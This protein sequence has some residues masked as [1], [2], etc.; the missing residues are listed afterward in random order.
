MPLS[1]QRKQVERYHRKPEVVKARTVTLS[2]LEQLRAVDEHFPVVED[3][4]GSYIKLATFVNDDTIRVSEFHIIRAH[5]DKD[6]IVAVLSPNSEA[7][8]RSFG[9]K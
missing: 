5:R 9:R 7:K 4:P 6:G 1:N 2:E 3:I 8:Q